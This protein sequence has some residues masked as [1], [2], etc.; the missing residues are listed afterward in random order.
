MILVISP[1]AAPDSG[2]VSDIRWRFGKAL[3]LSKTQNL[4]PG[5]GSSPETW[6]RKNSLSVI[7]FLSACCHRRDTSSGS[8]R[9]Y[10]WTFACPGVGPSVYLTKRHSL[11][12]LP[13]RA[14]PSSSFKPGSASAG[15]WTDYADFGSLQKRLSAVL[16]S[17]MLLDARSL[18]TKRLLVFG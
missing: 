12:A 5:R 3:S 4:L 14:P 1:N 7:P 2:A 8:W 9:I 10:E 15:S 18:H 16:E 13:L 6:R 17:L 11:P